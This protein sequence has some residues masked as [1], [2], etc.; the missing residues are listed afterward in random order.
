MSSLSNT[1]LQKKKGRAFNVFWLLFTFCLIIV[2]RIVVTPYR[3][4]YINV[5]KTRYLQTTVNGYWKK[6]ILC[7]Q[8]C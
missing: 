6:V 8:H 3:L 2:L 4:D 5:K 7:T 1:V